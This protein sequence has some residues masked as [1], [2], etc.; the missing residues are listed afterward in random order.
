MTL[1]LL[2]LVCKDNDVDNLF[3]LYSFLTKNEVKQMKIS[4][5]TFH[6]GHMIVLLPDM[7]SDPFVA[8]F[9]S[10][11]G[12]KSPWRPAFYRFSPLLSHKW[13]DDMLQR[14]A[15]AQSYMHGQHSTKPPHAGIYHGPHI[16]KPI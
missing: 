2:G 1:L 15:S 7:W 8:L 5:Y 6:F 16:G 11:Y 12:T 4:Q 14:H 9:Q 3:N 13:S 10:L